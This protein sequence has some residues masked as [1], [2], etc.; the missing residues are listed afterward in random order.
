MNISE[1]L[2]KERSR[3]DEN[4]HERFPL[5]HIVD[6]HTIASARRMDH[7]PT[8]KANADV[9]DRSFTAILA[10]EEQ[11]TR[12]EGWLHRFGMRVLHIGV[13]RD[14]HSDPLMQQAR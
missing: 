14:L 7:G 11:I 6:I 8:A 2:S 3:A 9:G 13:A 12:L 10:E 4:L 5:L 1:G